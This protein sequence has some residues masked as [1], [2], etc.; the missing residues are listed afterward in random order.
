MSVDKF[1]Y[2]SVVSM[3]EK[4]NKIS[5]DYEGRLGSGEIFDS[6]KH[7]E[8]SHPIEF[9]VGSGEVIQGFDNAVLGMNKGEEKEFTINPEDAYGE[10]NDKLKQEVPRASLPKEQEP[11]E[12]MILIVQTPQGGMP[13]KIKQVKDDGVVLDL[14]HPLAGKK[15]IFKIKI[16]EI[17]K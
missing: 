16:L 17:S 9:V 13:V 1:A 15:L 3:I 2:S 8:H 12:G 11:K 7:G 4:G 10:Y 14:N 6:S 5:V